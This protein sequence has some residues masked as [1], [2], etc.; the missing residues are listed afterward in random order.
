MAITLVAAVHSQCRSP[1][2]SRG[3]PTWVFPVI[4]VMLSVSM[5]IV[6]PGL[7]IRMG[8]RWF[9]I[10]ALCPFRGRGPFPHAARRSQE[11]PSGPHFRGGTTSGLLRHRLLQ[12]T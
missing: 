6:D 10:A 11:P 1:C 9:K 5:F 12:P 4:E 8:Y 7:G 3:G 2:D